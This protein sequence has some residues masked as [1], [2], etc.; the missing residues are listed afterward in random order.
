LILTSLS[1]QQKTRA[2]PRLALLKPQAA[3]TQ[4]AQSLTS[5]GQPFLVLILL[6]NAVTQDAQNNLRIEF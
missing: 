2:Q 6:A 3:V 5:C 1:L 4:T